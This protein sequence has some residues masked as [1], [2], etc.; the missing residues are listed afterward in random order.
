MKIIAWAYYQ[1]TGGTPHATLLIG[2]AIWTARSEE[3]PHS[4]SSPKIPVFTGMTMSGD[5]FSNGQS[6]TSRLKLGHS[7]L[8]FG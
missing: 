6:L 3:Q 1:K 5:S 2:D 4:S 8:G 7:A